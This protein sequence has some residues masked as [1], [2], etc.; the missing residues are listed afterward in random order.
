M[1]NTLFLQSDVAD[2]YALYAGMRARRPVHF[3]ERNGIWAVYSHAH[4]KRVLESA[5]A[6]IPAQH[7]ASLSAMSEAAQTLVT[8]FA[9]LANPPRHAE[10]RE[11]A[12]R[13]LGCMQRVDVAQLLSGLLG[14]SGECDWIGQVGKKLPALAVMK[15]FG[16]SD[17]DAASVLPRMERLIKIMLPNKTAA[18]VDDVNAVAGDVLA[19][20]ERHL[21]HAFPALAGSEGTLRLHASNLVGL[22]VQ[23]VDAGRGILG[24]ALLQA[25]RLPE[26]P[27]GDGWHSLV[28][29][30]L[31][32]DPPI[33]NTRRVLVHEIELDGIVLPEGVG[34]L[35]VL[36]SANRD[37]QVFENAGA[38]DMGRSNNAAHLT[39]GAGAHAC[40]AR[41]FATALAADA[42][43]AFFGEGRRVELLQDG[44]GY[45]A[46]VNARL[47]RE[48]RLR[49]SS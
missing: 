14:P 33:Q 43:R 17:S 34:V 19:I 36:A 48:I 27:Q 1:E 3:D 38:F 29:E 45:E 2:P 4:C 49:Y 31:R 18:Q 22:M 11:A 39:F 41:H 32:F 8:H 35:V 42:L 20:A 30:T 44:I 16:F 21:V 6:H 23:S 26:L 5:T 10:M 37:E 46:M 40:A 12:M 13:L 24:N 47:P 9:R 7:P 25:L 15:A 28:T